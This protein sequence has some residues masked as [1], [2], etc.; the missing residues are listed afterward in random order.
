MDGFREDGQYF[1]YVNE[2]LK[3]EPIQVYCEMQSGGWTRIMNRVNIEPKEF[4]S[5]NKSMQ[6]YTNGFGDVLLNHW[7]GL[8]TI[9]KL[10]DQEQMSL[11]TEFKSQNLDEYYIEYDQFRLS[12]NKYELNL[13]HMLNGSITDQMR[14]HNGSKFTTYDQDNDSE[15]KGNCAKEFN[16]GWWHSFYF[17][18]CYTCDCQNFDLSSE[19]W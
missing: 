17:G 8:Q 11:R 19:Y 16:G 13:G 2:S 1:I 7:L 3:L 10:C 18:T 14:F 6:E 12:D 5:F 9:K 15:T 4:G